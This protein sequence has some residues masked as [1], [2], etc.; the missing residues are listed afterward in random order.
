MSRQF[1]KEKAIKE[2]VDKIS[3]RKRII[4]KE[5]YARCDEKIRIY[6]EDVVHRTGGYKKIT[7]V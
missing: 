3:L 5:F 6:I 1:I 2:Y 4:G 7:G